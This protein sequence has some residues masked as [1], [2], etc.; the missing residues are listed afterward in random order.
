MFFNQ[1]EVIM[2][3]N[4]VS[5]ILQQPFL[6]ILSDQ[7]SLM[8]KCPSQIWH[9]FINL[10]PRPG[11]DTACPDG[12][13]E[14]QEGRRSTGVPSIDLVAWHAGGDTGGH[15]CPVGASKEICPQDD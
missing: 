2:K 3:P 1:L 15:R 12:S 9:A 7:S 10:K 4:G 11:G 8:P 14:E 5:F 6:L 13:R